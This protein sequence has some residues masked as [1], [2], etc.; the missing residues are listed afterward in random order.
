MPLSKNTLWLLDWAGEKT[1]Y[2]VR[3][4]GSGLKTFVFLVCEND[5]YGLD[6][7]KGDLTANFSR[8]AECVGLPASRISIIVEYMCDQDLD[9]RYQLC[10]TNRECRPVLFRAL[11]IEMFVLL[12]KLAGEQLSCLV[13]SKWLFDMVCGDTKLYDIT[14]FDGQ[15]YYY[16]NQYE[17][18]PILGTPIMQME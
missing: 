18:V 8:I 16:T 11:S 2:T 7:V 1:Q 6:D 4:L 17:Y 12:E 13:G 15:T 5:E 14:A 3:T 10:V 9:K